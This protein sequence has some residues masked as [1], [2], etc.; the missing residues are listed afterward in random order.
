MSEQSEHLVKSFDQDLKRLTDMLIRM[1]GIVEEL[2]EGAEKVSPSAQLRISPR[3]DKRFVVEAEGVEARGSGTVK[4]SLDKATLT[5]G[6]TVIARIERVQ[7]PR[8]PVA[9]PKAPLADPV[10][11]FDHGTAGH[12]HDVA[13]SP[14][15][16]H[17][18]AIDVAKVAKFQIA[19]LRVLFEVNPLQ[20]M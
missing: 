14:D 16:R 11:R 18:A 8:A 4:L 2:I 10:R 19:A 5:R 3:G 9:D 12:V 1:G 20:K 15:G 17:L 13:F 7:D 6:D